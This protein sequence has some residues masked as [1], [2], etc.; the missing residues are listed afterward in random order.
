M[1]F[2]MIALSELMFLFRINHYNFLQ[3]M[4]EIKLYTWT[5]KYFQVIGL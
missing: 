2:I 4:D 1:N 5:H 3:M